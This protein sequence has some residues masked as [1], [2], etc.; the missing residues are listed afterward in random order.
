MQGA[1][2]H[3]VGTRTRSTDL[4]A[5]HIY[6]AAAGSLGT[7][8]SIS[9]TQH[10]HSSITAHQDRTSTVPPVAV[11]MGWLWGILLLVG[12]RCAAGAGELAD[13]ADF[14]AAA[15]EAEEGDGGEAAEVPAGDEEAWYMWLLGQSQLEAERSALRDRRRWE[16]PESALNNQRQRGA[17]VAARAQ[18]TAASA[19]GGAAFGG[20]GGMPSIQRGLQ[21]WA[22]RRSATRT[23]RSVHLGDSAR[24][25]VAGD[26]DTGNA[27]AVWLGCA[28]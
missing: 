1:A 3:W 20:A 19:G 11:V 10:Q 22:R 13:E 9:T 14:L 12:L 8:S 21:H 15:G 16:D 4:R 7:H 24:D 23:G 6:M 2:P 17:G 28:V 26:A 25:P 5:R 27:A 18:G